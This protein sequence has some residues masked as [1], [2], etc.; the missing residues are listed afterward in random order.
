MENINK[1]KLI[2]DSISQLEFISRLILL[3]LFVWTQFLN[4]YL[5]IEN[6]WIYMLGIF[7]IYLILNRN[8]LKGNMS[9]KQEKN[10]FIN[11]IINTFIILSYIML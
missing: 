11:S 10:F 1:K 5:K 3:N 6:L 9:K 7:I 2:G 4:I 8:W